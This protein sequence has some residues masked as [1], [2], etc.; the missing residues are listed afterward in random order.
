VPSGPPAAIA[1]QVRFFLPAL[2]T[3]LV[4][5]FSE[6]LREQLAK[7]DVTVVPARESPQATAVITLGDWSDRLGTGQ[8]LIVSLLRDGRVTRVGHVWVPD[9][10]LGT[11]ALDRPGLNTSTD[12]YGRQGSTASPWTP[13]L[14]MNTLSVA[15]EDV[16]VVLVQL[17][18]TGS[19]PTPGT[20]STA[21][22]EGHGQTNL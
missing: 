22:R 13:D 17:L 12:F 20:E 21:V 5:G 4:D 15:A 14:T 9:L 6:S 2:G 11:N 10:G 8:G 1:L 18:R 7:Y 19:G 3:W 16:A